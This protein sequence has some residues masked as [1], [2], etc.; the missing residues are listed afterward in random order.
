MA[1][2]KVGNPKGEAAG[3]ERSQSRPRQGYEHVKPPLSEA[4]Y[5][6]RAGGGQKRQER[7]WHPMGLFG[8]AFVPIASSTNARENWFGQLT[9]SP[10]SPVRERSALVQG[11]RDCLRAKAVPRNLP[12]LQSLDSPPHPSHRGHYQP[13]TCFASDVR[14]GH[15]ARL[16]H[17]R[18]G[19]KNRG[20]N[21]SGVLICQTHLARLLF[22]SPW[23][24]SGHTVLPAQ[25]HLFIW[26]TTGCHKH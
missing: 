3:W 23:E 11:C 15:L 9:S 10:G 16:P 5:L 18:K 22:A 26:R 1:A 14:G 20:R 25:G 17:A 19:E 7:A 8:L 21:L 13:G 6:Q 12:C 4:V 2:W 24:R